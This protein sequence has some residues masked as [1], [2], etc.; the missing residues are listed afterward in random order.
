MQRRIKPDYQTV[1]PRTVTLTCLA[2]WDGWQF[3]LQEI[4]IKE[5]RLYTY[6]EGKTGTPAHLK[7]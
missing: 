1:V 7:V 4:S 2:Q 3:L 6:H 5:L